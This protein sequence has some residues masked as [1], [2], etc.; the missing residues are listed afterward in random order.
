MGWVLC[1]RLSESLGSLEDRLTVDWLFSRKP[2]LPLTEAEMG[3]EGEEG[4]KSRMKLGIQVLQRQVGGEGPD[5]CS[6]ASYEPEVSCGPDTGSNCPQMVPECAV[7][8]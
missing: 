7:P 3:P 5:L 6:V 2:H 1:P 8:G 4:A